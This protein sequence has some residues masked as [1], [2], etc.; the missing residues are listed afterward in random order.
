MTN[1]FEET[2]EEALNKKRVENDQERSDSGEIKESDPISNPV[3]ETEIEEETVIYSPP[4]SDEGPEEDSQEVKNAKRLA[5]IVV[6]DVVIYNEK[7]AEEGVSTGKFYEILEEEI[8]EGRQLYESRVDQRF[9]NGKDYL[10]EAFED[11]INKKKASVS[12]G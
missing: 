10:K 7:K 6:S 1:Y 12:T 3:G 2:L 4:T 9:L 5:R 8:E 11:F